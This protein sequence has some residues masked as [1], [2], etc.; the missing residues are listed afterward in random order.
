V[1][2]K[3]A[4]RVTV[5]QQ[6]R[7]TVPDYTTP[8]RGMAVTKKAAPVAA[9]VRNPTRKHKLESLDVAATA[10]T[11]AQSAH[12]RKPR[13]HLWTEENLLRTFVDAKLE[14]LAAQTKQPKENTI[15]PK[16][17]NEP[18]RED[19]SSFM[20]GF[21][22]L[23]AY[24]LTFSMLPSDSWVTAMLSTNERELFDKSLYRLDVT[25]GIASVRFNHSVGLWYSNLW[26]PQK[27]IQK[28]AKILTN[29][30]GTEGITS[31]AKHPPILCVDNWKFRALACIGIDEK[32]EE[33]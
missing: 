16:T 19:D 33:V 7:K 13:N 31:A 29:M 17:N 24:L 15:E 30:E 14:Y 26:M 10:A 28:H 3:L 11:S 20:A 23:M 22:G 4:P 32:E 1:T 27:P 9:V 12:S 25:N 18:S 8:N 6:S 5:I 21:T 2:K